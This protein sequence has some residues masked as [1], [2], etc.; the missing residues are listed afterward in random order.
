MAAERANEKARFRDPKIAHFYLKVNMT[1]SM[2][3]FALKE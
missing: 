1:M 2:H 3:L